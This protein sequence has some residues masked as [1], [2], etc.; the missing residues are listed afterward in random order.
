MA[1][2]SVIVPA[3]N[4]RET[5]AECLS[6]LESQSVSPTEIIVVDDGSRDD[7]FDLASGFET[8]KVIRRSA[9]GGAGAARDTGAGA[10][11]GDILAFIDTDCIAPM[12][13]VARIMAEFAADPELGALGGMY[14][15]LEVR[16][17]VGLFRKFEEEYLH[18]YFART[19][20]TTTLTGG[21]FAVRRNVWEEARSGRELTFFKNVA[22]SED[23]VVFD[24]IRALYP[25]RFMLDLY[26]VHKPKDDFGGFFRR[27]ILRARTR[28]RSQ[29]NDLVGADNLFPAF[30]GWKL[31][32]SATFLWL[33]LCAGIGALVLPQF[34][35]M[36]AG[37]G[38]VSLIL[39]VGTGKD[40]FG[41][42]H[43]NSERP[44]PVAVGWID[45]VCLRGLIALRAA[46]WVLGSIQGALEYAAGRSR[47]Y[48]N[49][50]ASITHFWM[51]GRISKLFYF[52]TSKCNARCSFCFNLENVVN[53]KER[54]KVE[55]SLDEVQKLT[56]N[57]GRLPYVTFSGGEP[58]AR[59]DLVEVVQA[60]RENARTQWV[61]IPTN[62]ALTKRVM[63]GVKGIL[64]TCP[65]LFL[66]IQFSIDSLGKDHDDSRKIKGG[67]Q[68]M[69]D[70]AVQLTQLRRHYK[71]L[72]I[73][74]NTPYDTFNMENLEQIREFCRSHFEFDQHF[75]YLFREDG[76][77][78]SEENVH[79]ADGFVDFIQKND[80][81]ELARGPQNLWARAVR[82]LQTVTYSDTRRIKKFQ[83]YIRPC[84]AM[85][86][87]ITLYDDG[88]LTPCEVLESR[89]L[90]NIRD[91]DFDFYRMQ[92]EAKLKEIHRKEILETNCN[93]EWM[94]AI[95]MNMLYDPKT[96]FKIGRN[97]LLPSA[98]ASAPAVSQAAEKPAE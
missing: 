41:F 11:Q 12:D 36:F 39:S 75:F 10:A 73:Q 48:W 87:F 34:W 56:A 15:H 7:T 60:F 95:P 85:L 49:V 81:E 72:R 96:W 57:F 9:Q 6:A 14:R 25:T 89:S 20:T 76:V 92:R 40:F 8:V 16:S 93:C 90:G 77:L 38:I 3:Y 54:Q 42:V 84:H 37:F 22:S 83:E 29:A 82:A 61:T 18:H 69:L 2:L 35:G 50:I 79:L 55:L 27:S 43:S 17:Q 4:S 66:T 51:P 26:V 67:F 21:N 46:C 19:P 47:H 31:F 78:I 86:K 23:T 88:S 13:W 63:M 44:G 65:D 53:W 58:F 70:T 68:A 71:N 28:T 80:E 98:G 52:V 59:I 24:E 62:G 91:Y 94:C 64:Q 45:D 5:I 30:G 32:L 74:V 33:A 1:S 97:F